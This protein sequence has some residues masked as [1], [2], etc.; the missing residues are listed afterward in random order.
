MITDKS[1][2]KELR[3][4]YQPLFNAIGY[5]VQN[6][7]LLTQAFTRRSAIQEKIEGAASSDYQNLE[8]LGDRV[9]N[10]VGNYP[11]T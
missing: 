9:L 7:A 5:H 11:G 4:K 1:D 2:T 3:R 6:L 10:L 8:Y